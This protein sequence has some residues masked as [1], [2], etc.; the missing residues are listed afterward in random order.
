MSG[1]EAIV[2]CLPPSG[3]EAMVA[4]LLRAF[5]PQLIGDGRG[6]HHFGLPLSLAVE[7]EICARLRFDHL[8]LHLRPQQLR[9]LRLFSACL[10][11]HSYLV[12]KPRLLS[13]RTWLVVANHPTVKVCDLHPV[14]CAR[15]QRQHRASSLL[16]TRN[17]LL[18]RH[19]PRER[20]RRQ[21]GS[22]TP[23]QRARTSCFCLSF[24]FFQCTHVKVRIYYIFK[25]VYF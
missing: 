23:R 1:L 9:T 15:R 3:Q 13:A 5:R 18:Q 19:W 8:V 6:T 10:L 4:R 22:L 11:N 7:A 2:L 12:P 24:C 21:G 16:R 20:F 14:R 25:T 17:C